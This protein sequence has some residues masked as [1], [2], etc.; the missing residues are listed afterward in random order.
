MERNGV[1]WAIRVVRVCCVECGLIRTPLTDGCPR[2]GCG[3][4]ATVKVAR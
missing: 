3:Q 1:K 2:C 4:G